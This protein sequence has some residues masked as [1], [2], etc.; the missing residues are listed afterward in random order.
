MRA[1]CE[2][3]GKLICHTIAAVPAVF[4]RQRGQG[5]EGGVEGGRSE[6]PY[7]RVCCQFVVQV[8]RTVHLHSLHLLLSCHDTSQV[9]EASGTIVSDSPDGQLLAGYTHLRRCSDRFKTGCG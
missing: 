2:V 8:K 1:T 6:M 3:A 9:A 4:S 5:G 7:Y